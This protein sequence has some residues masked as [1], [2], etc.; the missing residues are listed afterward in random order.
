MSNDLSAVGRDLANCASEAFL[1]GVRMNNGFA[2]QIANK[3]IEQIV[4]AAQ[5]EAE[6]EIVAPV[7]LAGF[8]E[9]NLDDDQVM[10]VL[11]R[12]HLLD[13]EGDKL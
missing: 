10:L 6:R 7:E 2:E 12:L 1:C 9:V 8:F 3:I 4:S 11:E 5:A 13:R